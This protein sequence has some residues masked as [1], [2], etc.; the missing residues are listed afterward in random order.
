MSAEW[1]E[2]PS[3]YVRT[4][5]PN[6][7]GTDPE[8]QIQGFMVDFDQDH[9]KAMTLYDLIHI[10]DNMRLSYEQVTMVGGQAKW[11][12]VENFEQ[13]QRRAELTKKRNKMLEDHE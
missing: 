11:V 6:A 1:A 9:G 7:T 10:V 5:E 13:A 3:K 2:H 4:T 8:P 12:D